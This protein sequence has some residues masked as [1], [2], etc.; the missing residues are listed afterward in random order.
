[1]IVRIKL[2]A[3]ICIEAGTMKEAREKGKGFHGISFHE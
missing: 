2:S 1:M 3:D